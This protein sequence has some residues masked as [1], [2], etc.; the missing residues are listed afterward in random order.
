MGWVKIF[1]MAGRVENSGNLHF[2]FLKID[3][4]VV[5]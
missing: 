3:L 5:I 1:V 4:L 2:V